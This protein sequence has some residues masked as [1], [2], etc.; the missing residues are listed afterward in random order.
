MIHA[1]ISAFSKCDAP[2]LRIDIYADRRA[3]AVIAVERFD[4]DRKTD[5]FDCAFEFVF[6]RDHIVRAEPERPYR[7][8]I[9]FVASL[10]PAM[11][12]AIIFVLAVVVA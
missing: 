9:F 6:I 4:D 2:R 10:L 5:R 1:N 11:S 3:F 8:R 7:P 12:T